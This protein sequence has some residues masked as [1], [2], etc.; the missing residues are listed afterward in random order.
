MKPIKSIFP[1]QT[2]SVFYDVALPL[3]IEFAHEGTKEYSQ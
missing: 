1:V 2:P 3:Y